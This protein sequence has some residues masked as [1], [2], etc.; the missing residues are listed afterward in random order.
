M[1]KITKIEFSTITNAE[2]FTANDN[3]MVKN[4]YKLLQNQDIAT[5]NKIQDIRLVRRAL[6]CGLKNGLIFVMDA[7]ESADAYEPADSM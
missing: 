1:R 4:L 2:T 3:P 6:D 7:Y 5:R